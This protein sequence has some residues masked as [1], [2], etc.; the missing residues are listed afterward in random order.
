MPGIGSVLGQSLGLDSAKEQKKW[1]IRLVW[2]LK[3]ETDAITL[4]KVKVK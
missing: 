4:D 3:T 1:I 2:D